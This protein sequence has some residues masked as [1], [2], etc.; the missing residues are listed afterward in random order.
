MQINEIIAMLDLLAPPVFQESYDNAGLI[1][2]N[3]NW[4]CSGI[5]VA[6]DATEP[7]IEEAVAKGCNLV[8]AHH[9]IVFGG[10]RKITGRNY[11]EKTVIRAIKQD[12][13]IF[14]IHTNLDN[15]RNGVNGR[16][17]SLLGLEQTR[18]LLPKTGLLRK[19]VSFVPIAYLDK[20]R[21]A[22]F[23]AGAGNIGAYSEC[24]FA[25]SGTGTFK[26]GAGTAP[27]VGQS[28]LRHNEAEIRLEMIYPAFRETA[29]VQALID[30]HPYE[31]VAYDLIALGNDYQEVGS[32]MIGQLAH[33][34]SETEFLELLKTR[35]RVP[36]VRH[37]P[38]LNRSI[39][40]VAVC[41]GAGSFMIS[42]ALQLN[43][44]AYVT[45]DLKYHEFF[46]ANGRILLADVGHFES[47]Q[48]TVDLL[49]DIL[50][51][52]FPTFAVFKTGVITNPVNYYR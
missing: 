36:V 7:I 45:A 23:A 22:L 40:R 38:P 16:I 29:V 27:F 9:P 6:L 34:L 14:A 10:L 1:C 21:E 4:E 12:V 3:G 19:L 28:G 41:G 43:A 42:N 37:S 47:E 49:Y 13:A 15:V 39:Q 35:F 20:V 51:E 32:G 5:L 48:Y 8:V 25:A 31:E 46:D 2:G 50:A 26:A 18:I 24:S 33:S 30:S 52:K 17:A 11:V 44:D